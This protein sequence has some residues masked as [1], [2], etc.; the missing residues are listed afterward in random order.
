MYSGTYAIRRHGVHLAAGST[1]TGQDQV[2]GPV[3]VAR[4]LKDSVAPVGEAESAKRNQRDYRNRKTIRPDEFPK[5]VDKHQ[6]NTDQR[7][8]ERNWSQLTPRGEHSDIPY[9]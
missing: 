9:T 7:D 4:I 2:R 5:S 6:Q 8:S 1:E 3:K